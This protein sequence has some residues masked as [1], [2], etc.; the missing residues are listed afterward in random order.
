M[1]KNTSI[2]LGDHFERFIKRQI[3]SGRYGSVSEVIRASLRLLEEQEQRTRALRQAL[4]DGEKSGDTG[5]LDMND[6][7]RKA[8]RRAKSAS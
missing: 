8:R 5:E 2:S 7:K 6:I 3:R 4:I 1:A